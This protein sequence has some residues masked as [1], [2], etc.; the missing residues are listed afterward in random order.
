MAPLCFRLDGHLI[1]RPFSTPILGDGFAS[2]EYALSPTCDPFLWVSMRASYDE[3][4]AIEP[5]PIGSLPQ[6]RGS[7]PPAFQTIF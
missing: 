4:N 2:M 6:R 5:Y 7:R 3:T 1:R